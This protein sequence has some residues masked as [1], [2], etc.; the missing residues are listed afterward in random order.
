MN[1]TDAQTIIAL[2][3]LAAAAD[4]NQ[5]DA[6]RANIA[7]AAT[8]LGLPGDDPRLKPAATGPGT[9]AALVAALS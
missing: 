7:A 5:S 2:A 4:G 3:A 6:E 9:V 8:R 1:P